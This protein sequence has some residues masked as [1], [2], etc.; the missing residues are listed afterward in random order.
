MNDLQKLAET[1]PWCDKF[2]NH[3][4]FATGRGIDSDH[5]SAMRYAHGKTA[6]E[7]AF[8]PLQKKYE[9]LRAIENSE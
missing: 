1:G 3:Y 6:E 2:W 7:M 4:S 8:L 5:E 9:I